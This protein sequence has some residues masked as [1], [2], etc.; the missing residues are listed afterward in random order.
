MVTL[1]AFSECFCQITAYEIAYA[2]SPKNMKALVLSIFL[3][4]NALSSALAEALTPAIVDP[5]L[6]WVWGG[7]TI[8]MF[9]ISVIFY[10]RYR[11]MNSDEFMTAEEMY[12]SETESR[13]D[14][15]KAGDVNTSSLP[16]DTKSVANMTV[17]KE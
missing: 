7:P 17:T 10:W 6:I 5:H 14:I 3:F 1:G 9:V 4:M 15:E 8:S 12:L 11:W 13:N 2:R 16:T